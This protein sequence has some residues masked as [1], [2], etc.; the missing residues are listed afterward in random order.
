MPRLPILDP[1]R[2]RRAHPP[3]WR[4]GAAALLLALASP[5]GL[6]AEPQEQAGSDL[7]AEPGYLDPARLDV[8]AREENVKVE[9]NFQGPLI[10]F[11]AEAARGTEPE[12]ADALSRLRSVVFRLYQVGPGEASGVRSRTASA[13]SWLEKR[14]WQRVVKVRDEGVETYVYLKTEGNRIVG[15]TALFFNDEEQF[16]FINVA[17]EIDPEQI[18]RIGRRLD[19]D[20]L[21]EAHAELEKRG[22]GQEAEPEP[23]P[24]E[25]PERPPGD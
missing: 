14:G 3:P 24:A 18:G 19:I 16:G 8:Y 12:L 10:Q 11:V 17:G 9:V 4:L 20:V 23:P 15:L 1:G 5:L 25:A 6:E 7:A 2:P 13:A 22:T 21:E